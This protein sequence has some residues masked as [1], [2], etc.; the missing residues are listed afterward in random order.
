VEAYDFTNRWAKEVYSFWGGRLPLTRP[1]Q[2]ARFLAPG[3]GP[4]ESGEHT[5]IPT[6]VWRLVSTTPG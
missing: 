3:I 1:G 6:L 5:I 4:V 2:P